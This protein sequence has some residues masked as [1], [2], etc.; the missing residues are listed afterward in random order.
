MRATYE[1]FK[2]QN[3]MTEDIVRF[4]NETLKQDL[5]PVFDQYLRRAALPVLEL[6]FD[7]AAGTVAYRWRADERGFAMPIRVGDPAKWQLIRPTTDWQVMPTTLTPEAFKVA[8]DLYYVDVAILDPAGRPVKSG[9]RAPPGVSVSPEREAR[10]RTRLRH[11]LE[12]DPVD[13]GG[14][15]AAMPKT[16]TPDQAFTYADAFPN[17]RKA[18]DEQTVATPHGDL[19]LRVPVREVSLGGGEPPS[20]STT[21]AA[22]R[23][24]TRA[25][26]L[27]KL[28]E[29]WIAPRRGARGRAA[30]TQ[31]HYAP[32]GRDHARDG[33]H[34]ARARAC[35]PSSSATRSR[36]AAPSSRPTSITR[37]SSR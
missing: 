23:A 37:S 8:T 22:R 13:T 30:V 12:P 32:Q 10:R 7:R 9:S 16:T 11:T 18:H 35:P 4:V 26:G 6:T 17:S 19:R 24:T 33:V 5:T 29:P 15:R 3:I 2:Y 20:G 28:R 25:Q 21:R 34:R 1:R 31:L 27:P 36:A 14:G